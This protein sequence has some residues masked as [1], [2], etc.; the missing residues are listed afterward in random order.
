MA[1]NRCFADG[2]RRFG[3]ETSLCEIASKVIHQQT[4][5]ISY[6]HENSYDQ[7]SRLNWAF[8]FYNDLVR[9]LRWRVEAPRL[10]FHP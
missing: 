10:P 7:F 5:I 8:S 4:Q 3:A 9:V 6:N 2:R 1:N